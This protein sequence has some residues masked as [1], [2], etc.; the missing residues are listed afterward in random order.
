MHILTS[1][2]RQVQHDF[3][4]NSWFQLC[5]V[6]KVLVKYKK[7]SITHKVSVR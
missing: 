1:R 6:I 3:A 4:L 2:M 7:N 5:M